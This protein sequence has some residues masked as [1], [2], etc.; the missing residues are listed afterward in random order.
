MSPTRG[1]SSL[2]TASLPTSNWRLRRVRVR[3]RVR[4]SEVRLT[5]DVRGTTSPWLPI[6]GH[7][8]MSKGEAAS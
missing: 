8:P 7:R 3:V 6:R 5:D 1:T 4:V 2:A